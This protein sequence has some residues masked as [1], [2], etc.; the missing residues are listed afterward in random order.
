MPMSS[1]VAGALGMRSMMGEWTMLQTMG[2]PCES[3][4]GGCV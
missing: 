4:A 2:S 1:G 3:N